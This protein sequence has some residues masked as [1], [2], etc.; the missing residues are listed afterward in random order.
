MFIIYVHVFEFSY[1]LAKPLH[2]GL[3]EY[4]NFQFLFLVGMNS[5]SRLAALSELD[6]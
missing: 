1:E 3:S 5:L 6:A 4:L 2:L